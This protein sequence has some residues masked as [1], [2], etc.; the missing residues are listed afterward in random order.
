ML[1]I[2][3]NNT[4]YVKKHHT[5]HLKNGKSKKLKV[6]FLFFVFGALF[7]SL[8]MI[9]SLSCG[10]HSATARPFGK[11]SAIQMSSKKKKIQI[12]SKIKIKK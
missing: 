1:Y 6:F 4:L 7:P 5:K 3:Q 8:G 10:K 9:F 12:S 11:H 2:S